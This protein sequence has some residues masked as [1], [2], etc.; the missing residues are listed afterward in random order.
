MSNTQSRSLKRH[1]ITWAALTAACLPSLHAQ[2]VNSVNSVNNDE[3]RQQYEARIKAL[4]DKQSAGAS[5]NSFNPAISMVLSGTYASLRRDPDTWQLSAFAPSGGETGP[6][7][8]SF[9]LGESEIGLSA[10]VDAWLYGAL[11]LAVSPEDT[12]AAEEAYIQTTALPN[13]LKIKVG[14]F[15]GGLGYLNEHHAHT[16]DF[17]D[18]PLPYQA[19]LGGKYKQEGLQTKW[20]LPTD[21]F[22]ELGAE[23]GNGASYPGNDR[24][25]NSAGSVSVFAHTGGDLGVDNTWRAGL[26]WLQTHAKDRAWD[27]LDPSTAFTGQSKLWVAD[28]VWK[29]APNGNGTRTSFKLQGEYFRRTETGAL[30]TEVADTPYRSAQSGGY[31]QGVYQFMPAWRVGLRHD[32]LATDAAAYSPKRHS[33]MLDWSPSEFSRW[34]VQLSDDHVR[35]GQR[36]RQLFLQYQMSL[37]AHGAHSY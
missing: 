26:S 27:G 28:G 30:T 17:I 19:F 31:L 13:G 23:L 15:F 1:A 29:W 21:Q 37:G 36:D 3:W 16:W 25:R 35:E 20:L 6:G 14:R 8:R 4:E 18:A 11:T 5:K 22:I 12:I 10:N 9:S 2:N 24:N 7:K 34:R 33:L 32:R